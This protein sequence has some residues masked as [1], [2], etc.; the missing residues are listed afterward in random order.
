MLKLNIMR[1]QANSINAIQMFNDGNNELF[2]R[3]PFK[4]IIFDLELFD[5]NGSS[6]QLIESQMTKYTNYQLNYLSFVIY[7]SFSNVKISFTEL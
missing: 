1:N 7:F 4:R 6:G 3:F 5:R 2:I